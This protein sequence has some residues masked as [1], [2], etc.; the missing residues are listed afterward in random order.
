MVFALLICLI[1]ISEIWDLPELYFGVASK[2]AGVFRGSVL[3]TAVLI[4]AI[5]MVGNTYV[6]QKRII[7]GLIVICAYCGRIQIEHDVWQEMQRY[8]TKRAPVAFS[9][10]MCPDCYLKL[11]GEPLDE[12]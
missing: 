4:C 9:H 2:G 8:L 10:G 1:W 3:T 7:H 6:Q 11:T 12:R 5:I